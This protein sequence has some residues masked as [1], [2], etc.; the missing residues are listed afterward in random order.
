MGLSIVFLSGSFH[1]NT[2]FER[3]AEYSSQVVK[4]ST[5]DKT[6][7]AI[8]FDAP[9]KNGAYYG[10]E[11]SNLFD[12]FRSGVLTYASAMNVH[13]EQDV[14]LVDYSDYNL[15]LFFVEAV[16]SMAI[17][18][19]EGNTVGWRHYQYNIDTMFSDP[20]YNGTEFDKMH[21]PIVYLS[22]QQ[23]NRILD[24]RNV[25]KESDEYKEEDY[26][27]LIKT[28]IRL[29]I[30]GDECPYYIWNIF[31]NNGF[32]CE[33]LTDV[34]GEYVLT[35]YYQPEKHDLRQIHKSLYYFNEY[36]Y[37]NQYLMRYLNER[38]SE[39]ALSPS[40]VKNNIIKE[41][42]VDFLL[43]FFHNETI[44]SKHWIY[45]SLVIVAVFMVAASAFFLFKSEK[46]NILFSLITFAGLIAPYI[47][48]KLIYIATNDVL[49]FSQPVCK[50][51]VLL[52]TVYVFAY[53]Y[54]MLIKRRIESKNN[55][56]GYYEIDI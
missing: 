42:N 55:C 16:G 47:V 33:G 27:S 43:S 31:Y 54:R 35:S 56:L 3:V 13:K 52:V 4:T 9:N 17:T 10:T 48:F 7:C 8:S 24:S 40:I 19:D 50:I 51:D 34:L 53:L 44:F 30:D 25:V 46:D 1:E 23:A 45:T 32:Y 37:Y 12:V 14:R 29:T 21:V 39:E 28:E 6:Y 2:H 15:S 49:F 36:A 41:V 20:V 5:S 26:E 11:L 38:Y 18:D 22:Q